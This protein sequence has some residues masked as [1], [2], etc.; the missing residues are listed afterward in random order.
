MLVL[1]EKDGPARVAGGYWVGGDG[2]DGFVERGVHMGAGYGRHCMQVDSP[3]S[4]KIDDDLG[5]TDM[6]QMACM[7]AEEI[8][9]SA[10]QQPTV[11]GASSVVSHLVR[12]VRQPSTCLV[13]PVLPGRG[14]SYALPCEIGQD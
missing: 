13:P 7:H 10:E 12:Q 6:V 4:Y 11:R 5:D 3:M 2:D 9:S 1:L 8:Q 14:L